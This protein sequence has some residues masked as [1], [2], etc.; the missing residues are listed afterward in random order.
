MALD[1]RLKKAMDHME[2][3]DQVLRAARCR[4]HAARCIKGARPNQP[5]CALSQLNHSKLLSRVDGILQR[6]TTL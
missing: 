2:A 4:M 1:L 6:R 3:Q 5:F